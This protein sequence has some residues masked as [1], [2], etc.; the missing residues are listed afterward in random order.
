[1][2]QKKVGI[3]PEWDLTDLYDAPDNKKFSADMEQLKEMVHEFEK[4]FKNAI[5]IQ[6]API[7][8]NAK[9]LKK[10]IVAYENIANVMGRLSGFAT[11][12]HVTATNDPVRTKFYGDTQ[13]KITEI[14]NKIIF[15]ELELNNLS[16][17]ILE[18]LLND[19][20]LSSYRTWFENIRKYKPHQLSD[21]VEQIFHD[22]SVTSFSAWNR[23]F[24]QTMSNMKVDID[25]DSKSLEE[26]LNYL[27]SSQEKDRKNA[28]LSVT[29][30]LKENISLFT[31]IM[32][33]IC[34]DKSISD[35]WRKYKYSEQSRHLANNIEPEVV[36]ALV[37]AV[38]LNYS[39]TSHRYYKLKSEMLG[40]KYLESWD[41][42]A[43]LPEAKSKEIKWND[44][45][46]IVIEAY[47]EF[48]PDLAKIVKR[49]F[50][51]KWIDAKIKDGKVTGAF[52]HPVTTDTHPYILMNYQGKP[53][54]VM[55]LA[56]ELGHG[57]HQVLASDLGPLLSDTPLTL[58]E[59]A[60]VFGEMLT[61]KKLIKNTE[62]EFERKV[63]LA[64]KI[65]DMINTVI[66]QISFFKFEQLVHH[67]RKDGE[68]TSEDINN[69][70]LET[71][72]DSLG[73]SI[74]LHKQHKYLWSY[75]PHFI[76][77]PF[78][79]YAY[80]F[81][82]C[83]V[84]SLY[85]VYQK[86]RSGFV[87]KYTDLLA[88]GGSKHHTQLLQPFNLDATDPSFWNNGISLITDMIDDLEKFS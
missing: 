2:L 28:F 27:L 7:S 52:A 32:N 3:L 1:M 54:D 66:R 56:H 40:K 62:D 11:L 82:D 10:S 49:F 78:Y 26:A 81:G 18:K 58:A 29:S 64:S 60:S 83:L 16:N 42:N 84:N 74:K 41:R 72:T 68:L 47:E 79:V 30:K 13:V 71:Q 53:R 85:S 17:E 65:E 70:W 22:K 4:E 14:S 20:V 69:I 57:V 55:T 19:K 6:D 15:F 24:D 31:H 33:T 87:Q 43:P 80:A 44:A 34:Q 35:K 37:N 77:S 48:S 46:D 8:D 51:E 59:T 75:I 5:L 38:E 12:H 50:D 88:S 25:G 86:D 45:R 9:R 63:L 76:H 73:P 61:Y 67:S 21:E 39:N 36:D 23:L